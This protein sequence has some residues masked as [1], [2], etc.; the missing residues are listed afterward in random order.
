MLIAQDKLAKFETDVC[1]EPIILNVQSDAVPE[2][3]LIDTPGIRP[4]DKKDDAACLHD[5]SL[6]HDAPDVVS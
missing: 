5:N 6:D 2:L 1:N 3:I 4:T